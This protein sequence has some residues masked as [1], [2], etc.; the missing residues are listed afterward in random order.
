MKK[1]TQYQKTI[2]IEGLTDDQVQQLKPGQWVRVYGDVT[3]Q[4]LGI[5]ARGTIT[6]NYKQTRDLKRQYAAN[7]PLRKFVILHGGK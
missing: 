4:F 3:G 5:T 1:S 6:I 2:N 7:Q